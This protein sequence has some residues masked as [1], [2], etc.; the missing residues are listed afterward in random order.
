M[1]RSCQEGQQRFKASTTSSSDREEGQSAVGNSTAMKAG[2]G[3]KR[4]RRLA[5]GSGRAVAQ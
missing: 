3:V 4:G 5:G 2:H 1:L